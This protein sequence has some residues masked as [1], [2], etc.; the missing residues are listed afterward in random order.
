MMVLEKGSV[1]LQKSVI[2]YHAIYRR[3]V[4]Q[5]RWYINTLKMY[6]V[7]SLIYHEDKFK[8]LAIGLFNWLLNNEFVILKLVGY[9]I[10]QWLCILVCVCMCVCVC[11]CVHVCACMCLRVCVHACTP[12]VHARVCVHCACVYACL[13]MCECVCMCTYFCLCVDI[14]QFNWNIN[15]T[16]HVLAKLYSV[17]EILMPRLVT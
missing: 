9:L 16:I 4:I 15:Y 12:G 14:L 3:I 10:T 5:R 13:C 7:A 11:V 2:L 1:H 17:W 8:V 6:I